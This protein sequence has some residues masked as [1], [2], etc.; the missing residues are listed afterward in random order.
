MITFEQR[1]GREMSSVVSH[2]PGAPHPLER[3]RASDLGLPW[4]HTVAV[5]LKSEV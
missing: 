5:E 3:E 2:L 1:R 4:D